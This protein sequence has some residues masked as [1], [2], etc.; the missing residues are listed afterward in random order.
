M[1][2]LLLSQWLEPATLGSV[3]VKVTSH[4][5]EVSALTLKVVFVDVTPTDDEVPLAVAE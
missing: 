3:D 1:A 2:R 4:E 5:V